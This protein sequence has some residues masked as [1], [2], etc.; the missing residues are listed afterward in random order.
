MTTHNL[1]HTSESL[2][3]QP[4]P[5]PTGL[6]ERQAALSILSS[7]VSIT[8]DPSITEYTDIY[9]S[10]NGI[11]LNL[12]GDLA[13]ASGY[14]T[15]QFN[16]FRKFWDH[17]SISVVVSATAYTDGTDD[18]DGTDST[19]DDYDILERV[20]EAD[21]Y[22]WLAGFQPQLEVLLG[23]IAAA[24]RDSASLAEIYA[25][26][27]FADRAD[28][29]AH[30]ADYVSAPTGSLNYEDE[31]SSLDADEWVQQHSEEVFNEIAEEEE[32]Q[33][34]AEPKRLPNL[35][36]LH[37]NSHEVGDD[38]Y[39]EIDAVDAD[40]EDIDEETADDFAEED[41]AF[42]STGNDPIEHDLDDVIDNDPAPGSLLSRSEIEEAEA[43]QDAPI[44]DTETR[45]DSLRASLSSA[46]EREA[47][48]TAV[49][50]GMVSAEIAESAESAESTESVEDIGDD[51]E[52]DTEDSAEVPKGDVLNDDDYFN[53]LRAQ[54]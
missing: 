6:T 19:D 14:N 11:V 35:G 13:E 3:T 36:D 53:K 26:A 27:E 7:L 5:G 20:S 1:T 34:D 43:D 42:I 38:D 10:G 16:V 51:T 18:T 2:P 9:K 40:F 17:N 45:I 31:E 29:A 49:N 32:L 30:G 24:H 47:E 44:E 23:T 12:E 37:T 28:A 41:G 15:I 39:V 46:A 25:Q 50:E 22:D 4:N 8:E 21:F 54:R 33:P 48:D 52:S